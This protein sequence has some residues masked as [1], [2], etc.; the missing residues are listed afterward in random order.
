MSIEAAVRRSC[1]SG[2]AEEHRLKAHRNVQSAQNVH[3]T[4]LLRLRLV[5]GTASPDYES[6]GQEFESLRAR[7]KN[8]NKIGV[9]AD[10]GR[11]GA[12]Q[13]ALA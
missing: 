12:C 2:I 8:L 9:L 10:V 6:G 5:I 4:F 1:R 7:Q 11:R 3:S 13:A